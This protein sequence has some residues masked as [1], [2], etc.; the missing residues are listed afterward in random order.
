MTHNPY[1]ASLISSLILLAGWVH[2]PLMAQGVTQRFKTRAPQIGDPLPDVEL[3][4][5]N[6][7][8]FST[9]EFKGHYTVLVFG[10]LT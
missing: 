9:G 4:D 1:T 7:K 10:C 3:L 8:P 5:L 6:G 2:T